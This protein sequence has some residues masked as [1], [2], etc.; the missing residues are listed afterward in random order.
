M[1]NA[2][3]P[4]RIVHTPSKV[5]FY[6]TNVKARVALS[7]NDVQRMEPL[8]LRMPQRIQRPKPKPPREG[9]V[10]TIH[11]GKEA[12][13]PH[14]IPEWA[15]VRGKDQSDFVRDG[16]A[17]KSS[18]SR[19]FSKKTFPSRKAEQL[20]KYLEV[21]DPEALF[22]HPDDDWMAR[23][24][25]GREREETERIKAV[26]PVLFPKRTSGHG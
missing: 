13:K 10:T 6:A 7:P 12:T 3:G 21:G 25:Q 8:P 5:A 18:V 4:D 16:I 2:V 23:F 9:K 26:L 11:R 17:D 20:A 24:L 22:R 15:E 19:W 1:L 14:F